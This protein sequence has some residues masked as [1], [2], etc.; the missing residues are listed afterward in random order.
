MK[1]NGWGASPVSVESAT[2]PKACFNDKSGDEMNCVNGNLGAIGY[3]DAD[4]SLSSYGNTARLKY[5]GEEASRVNIRNGRYDFWSTQWI[6]ENPAAPNYNVTHPWVVALMNFASDPDNV[7]STKAAY[8]AA[9][10]EMTFMK[11]TDFEYPLYL[12]AS[13]PQTP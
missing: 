10:N 13:D 3:A 11:G 8:W 1:G 6:F 4:Q 7:P 9:K 5:Q 2:A 12:G